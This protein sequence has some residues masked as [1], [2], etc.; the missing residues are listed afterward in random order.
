MPARLKKLSLMMTTS[1]VPKLRMT[2][3]WVILGFA[4]LGWRPWVIGFVFCWG[5]VP[6]TVLNFVVLHAGFRSA[7]E[8]L[9]QKVTPQ[10]G[11]DVTIAD[12]N[13]SVEYSRELECLRSSSQPRRPSR[14]HSS[15][16]RVVD[17]WRDAICEFFM[18]T[19]LLPQSTMLLL[20]VRT[21]VLIVTFATLGPKNGT[22][23]Y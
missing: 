19:I 3:T 2:F 4:R 1:I 18:S 7:E 10:F 5:Q 21:N 11:E 9:Q 13:G 16:Y 17:E 15:S 22:K 8:F 14:W 23:R 6:W 20:I 12:V